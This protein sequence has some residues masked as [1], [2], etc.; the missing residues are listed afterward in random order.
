MIRVEEGDHQAAARQIQHM[1]IWKT[2][3]LAY[4][5]EGVLDCPRHLTQNQARPTFVQNPLKT[6]CRANDQSFGLRSGVPPQNAITADAEAKPVAAVGSLE[7]RDGRC[8]IHAFCFARAREI[9]E[10]GFD[11]EE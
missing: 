6:S 11:T 5:E 3:A 7:A 8:T 9:Q 1:S 4:M 2:P 10:R